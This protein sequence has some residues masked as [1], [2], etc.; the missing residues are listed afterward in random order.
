MPTLSLQVGLDLKGQMDRFYTYHHTLIQLDRPTRGLQVETLEKHAVH[1][2]SYL[3]YIVK[4]R[5]MVGRHVSLE[6]Y[7]DMGNILAFVA[8]LQARDVKVRVHVG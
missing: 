3:G 7:R 2:R 1:I 8:Y 4:H 5:G 6:L